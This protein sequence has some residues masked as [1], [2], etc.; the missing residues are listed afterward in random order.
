[1]TPGTFRALKLRPDQLAAVVMTQIKGQPAYVLAVRE[2]A[3]G[4]VAAIAVLEA[5]IVLDITPEDMRE[6]ARAFIRAA[7]REPREATIVDE[8]TPEGDPL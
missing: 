2:P 6:A 4:L 8:R 1:M 7:G 5:V 3:D